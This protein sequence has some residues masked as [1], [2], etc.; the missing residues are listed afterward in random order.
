MENCWIELD[1]CIDAR[2]QPSPI[3]RAWSKTSVPGLAHYRCYLIVSQSDDNDQE[4]AWR[5][6]SNYEAL[7]SPPKATLSLARAN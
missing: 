7:Q 6:A 5:P 2:R 1:A 4:R 3:L